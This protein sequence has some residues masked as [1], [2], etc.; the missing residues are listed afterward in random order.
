M[1]LVARPALYAS[2]CSDYKAGAAAL[3]GGRRLCYFGSRKKRRGRPFVSVYTSYRQ[4]VGG[5]SVD[6]DARIVGENARGNT[7]S[8]GGAGD[9]KVD[10]V[11]A[12]RLHSEKE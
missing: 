8:R 11:K 5:G 3:P 1:V 9:V 6:G 10:D 2:P 4:H 7:C 12:L